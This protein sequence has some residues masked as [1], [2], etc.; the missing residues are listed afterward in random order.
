MRNR[1]QIK[2]K[3]QYGNIVFHSI[4]N[5]LFGLFAFICIYPFYYIF[6]Y[7]LSSPDKA[8]K[9]LYLYPRG[10]TLYNYYQLLLNKGIASAALVTVE[11]TILGSVSAVFCTA[12]FGY[13]LSKKELPLR[14]LIYRLVVM[15][16]YINAGLIPY[17]MLIKTLGLINSFFVYVIPYMV[18][19][20]NLILIKT[21]IEQ[22]PSSIEESA[23]MDGAGFLRIFLSLILP[24]STPIIAT[25]TV[26]VATVQ[27]NSFSDNLIFVTNTKYQTLQM[28]LYRII[29]SVTEAMQ[30]VRTDQISRDIRII[31]PTPTTI[32]MTMTMIATL[33]ILFAYPFL[34]RYFVK[35]IMLGAIKG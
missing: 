26:F 5:L 17:Y 8:A 9:G 4:N 18:G 6:I 29:S 21:Y 31:Q 16:M 25:V 12:L 10:I 22:I 7:S 27:W 23:M 3:N 35:G 20:F 1:T 34:Q 32:R 30:N 11:R 33:P 28:I 2:I 13:L 19:A 24:I 14:K 15:T